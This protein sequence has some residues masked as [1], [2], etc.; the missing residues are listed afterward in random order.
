MHFVLLQSAWCHMCMHNYNLQETIILYFLYVIVPYSFAKEH[1][2][3]ALPIFQLDFS[4]HSVSLLGWTLPVQLFTHIIQR[5][6]C[7]SCLILYTSCLLQYHVALQMWLWL[8]TIAISVIRSLLLCGSLMVRKSVL[9][10]R[11][12]AMT[13]F[14]K[15]CMTSA[16]FVLESMSFMEFL[17]QDLMKSA[18]D[19]RQKCL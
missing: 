2:S 4:V 19:Q 1:P 10:P 5:Y 3:I 18:V 7:S 9:P 16:D 15:W 6:R 13:L 17:G 14:Q 11:P 8:A 12:N